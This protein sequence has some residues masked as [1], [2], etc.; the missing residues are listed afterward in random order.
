MQARD[1]KELKGLPKN[2]LCIFLKRNLS[3]ADGDRE[4]HREPSDIGFVGRRA[5]T[6]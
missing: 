1:I 5:A 2:K 4:S 6:R 3:V